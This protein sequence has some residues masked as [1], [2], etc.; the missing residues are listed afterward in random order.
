MEIGSEF[1]AN[2]VPRGTNTYIELANWSKRYVLSGRTGLHLIAEEIKP[3]VAHIL[4]PDYCCGSMIA[5]F[6]SQGFRIS[7]YSAF[8]LERVTVDDAADAVLI[9]DYFGFLSTKTSAFAKQLRELAKIVILDATQTAFSH[10]PAYAFADYIVVSYRKWFDSLCA[11]VYSRCGFATTE[12]TAGH[13]LYVDTWRQAASLKAQY[14]KRGEGDKQQFLSLYAKANSFLDTQYRALSADDLEIDVAECADSAFVRDRRRTN[15]KILMDEVKRL[16]KRYD[17]RLMYSDMQDEDCPLFVPILV[18]EQK[19]ADIRAE[20]S[21]NHVYCPCHWP[22]DY[23][24]PYQETCYHKGEISLICDQ[25]YG[26]EEIQ[27][28]I[29]ALRRALDASNRI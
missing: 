5:P 19:R 25:R 18:E 28:Q 6:V 9:M 8:D 16:E 2:S 13:P 21:K 10:S 4:L 3:R 22:I 29:M 1:H 14:V 12:R 20:L 26:D 7:F 11:A 27:F 23:R 24:Y 17:I 15:A